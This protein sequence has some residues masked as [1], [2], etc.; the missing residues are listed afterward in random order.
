MQFEEILKIIDK[1]S[2]KDNIGSVEIGE[3]SFYIKVNTTSVIDTDNKIHGL[4]KAN[5]NELSVENL[6]KQNENNTVSQDINI[7]ETELITSPLVGIFYSSPSAGADPFVTVGTSVKKGEVLAIVEAMKL[8]NEIESECEGT[9][10]E[11]LAENGKP[12][13]YGKPLF[14]IKKIN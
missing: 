7:E 9:I 13:E 4:D 11:V 6:S 10:T 14:R 1:V 2:S 5:I 8:M 3:G 12:V